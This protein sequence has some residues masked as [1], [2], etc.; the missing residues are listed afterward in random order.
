MSFAEKLIF[1][2]IPLIFL[3]I[4]VI[5]FFGSGSLMEEVKSATNKIVEK[6]SLIKIGAQTTTAGKLTLP[7]NQQTV[8]DN[9]KATMERMKGQQDCFYNFGVLPNLGE[10]GTS[11]VIVKI[12]E[13]KSTMTI[14]GGEEGLQEIVTYDLEGIQPCVVNGDI[15]GLDFKSK[16]NAVA[17]MVIAYDAPWTSSNQNRINYGTGFKDFNSQG[18][19]YTPDGKLICFFPT[20][21]GVT[22]ALFKGE[23]SIGELI[24]RD[25]PD[26]NGR[27]L[28]SQLNCVKM[29]S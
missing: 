7:S 28:T 16:V 27:C 14:N 12:N 2:I 19:L 1:W 6:I 24:K 22:E 18:W 21:D 10:K 8:I 17:Q 26:L 3:V 23:N 11:I 5:A 20:A 29:C 25:L 13:E 15:S 4:I 9:L